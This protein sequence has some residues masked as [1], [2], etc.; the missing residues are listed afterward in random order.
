M[1]RDPD[2]GFAVI[3]VLLMVVVLLSLVV[4]HFFL[5]NVEIRT[6]TA[7]AASSSG[8]YAAESGLNLRGDDIL[9]VFR[10]DNLPSGTSPSPSDPCTAGNLGSGDFACE[11][12]T[13][14]DRDVTTY[15]VEDAENAAGGQLILIPQNELFAG[16][17]ALESRYS[18]FSR[19]THPTSERVEAILEMIFRSR[20][21]PIFQFAAFYNK[22]LEINPGPDMTLNG[23]VHANGNL[24]LTSDGNTLSIDGQVTVA[25][26]PGSTEA[27]GLYRRRKDDSR[28]T[29]TVRVDDLSG[30]RDVTCAMGP[31]VAADT[32]EAWNG[33]I[34][35]GLDTLTVPPLH[36]FEPGGEYWNRAELRVAL[37]LYASPPEII[38]RDAN[39][40]LNSTLTSR[41]R[42]CGM[43]PG[44]S[45]AYPRP[46]WALR[47]RAVHYSNSFHN[48]REGTKIQMLEVD[49]AGV[50]DCL[51]EYESDFFEF[52][53][54]I[55]DTTQGGLVFFFTV[56]GPQQGGQNNYGVRLRNGDRLASTRASAP[57]I[58]GLTVVSDQAIY[59]QGHYNLN[60][61]WKPASIIADSLNILSEAYNDFDADD[62]DDDDY[63]DQRSTWSVGSRDA[64][65]TEVNAAFLAGTDVTGGAEGTPGHSIG[66]YN[67]GLENYP[68]FH[69]DWSGVEFRYR[70]S[71]VSFH[72]PKHVDGR[73]DTGNVYSAPRRVWE[74]DERFNNINLLPPMSPNFVYLRQELF[75][76]QFEQ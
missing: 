68:R 55:D 31:Q 63:T 65:P 42:S 72:E 60:S 21:V 29:G 10:E 66:N 67:G 24:Y 26:R 20:V 18:V 47:D 17:N 1:H 19:A 11:H 8:F 53:N 14:N 27:T 44:S 41:L 58:Q 6:T 28:C 30:Y 45:P 9:T 37:N 71:F 38:V 56:E 5:T 13:L 36:S 4:A 52:G 23:R 76:R 40:S 12:F 3:T 48:Y 57:E 75:V 39:G 34:Q 49:V 59:V 25:K 50:L 69:E 46:D 2:H 51:D 32:L 61:H 64:Q 7:Q 73:W 54:G 35:T 15:V 22:D 16:L 33:Q 70:G 43:A 74:Y 62:W